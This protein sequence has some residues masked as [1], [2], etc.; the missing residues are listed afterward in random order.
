M[1]YSILTRGMI[2]GM[3]GGLAGTVS[4]YLFGAGIFALLGWPANTSV[5]TIGDSGAAFFSM[6]GIT[7]TGGSPLGL[8]LYYLIGLT[9]GT[10]LGAAAASLE[11]LRLASLKKRVVFSIL[12]VEVM[13]IPLLAA[14]SL[15]LKMSA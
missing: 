14:G 6:F 9:L 11:S 7:L 13:S 10:V 8:R 15:A 12:F 3:V 5:S 2:A 1:R 4:M